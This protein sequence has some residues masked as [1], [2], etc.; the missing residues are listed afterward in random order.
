[1]GKVFLVGGMGA[2]VNCA[3][4]IRASTLSLEHLVAEILVQP[5]TALRS[6]T[7]AVLGFMI[8]SAMVLAWTF[9]RAVTVR[10]LLGYDGWFLKPK[11]PINKVM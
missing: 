5:F 8:G 1:M 9:L 2:I 6:L 3:I 7:P 4:A 11:N 10:F